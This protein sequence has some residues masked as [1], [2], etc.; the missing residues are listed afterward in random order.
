MSNSGQENG[1]LSE[2]SSTTPVRLQVGGQF[3]Y[4]FP[5]N[6]NLLNDM[7]YEPATEMN[8]HENPV[9]YH[10]NGSF[11]APKPEYD[12]NHNGWASTSGSSAVNLFDE[13]L[14]TQAS[15]PQV[16]FGFS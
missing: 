3:Q 9:D 14:Y 13:P 8:P 15:S 7:K 6:F 4:G 2:L 11:E 16:H 10:V 5:Y 1:V 12:N